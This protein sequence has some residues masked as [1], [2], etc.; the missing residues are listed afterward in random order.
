MCVGNAP[1]NTNDLY[2]E[3]R[4]YTWL[5]V[6]PPTYSLFELGGSLWNKAII[7]LSLPPGS[8]ARAHIHKCMSA[9]APSSF[10]SYASRASTYQHLESVRL[11]RLISMCLLKPSIPF[12]QRACEKARSPDASISSEKKFDLAIRLLRRRHFAICCLSL[13]TGGKDTREV[14]RR[15]EAAQ[16]TPVQCAKRLPKS[17]R[18][19]IPP[20]RPPPP[21]RSSSRCVLRVRRESFNRATHPV[22]PAK[23]FLSCQSSVAT[24]SSRVS[25]G[26]STALRGSEYPSSL[27]ATRN[28]QLNE[29]RDL[30]HTPSNL[31]PLRNDPTVSVQCYS[32]V[33]SIVRCSRRA[34][35]IFYM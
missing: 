25:A 4:M 14:F 23:R 8:R 19:H 30:T 12:W 29:K 27:L 5:F 28:T 13:C 21:C 31:K 6:A 2:I 15:V 7:P 22:T 35:V 1:V 3:R 16:K 24:C 11:L 20:T 34:P 33:R 26:V 9:R 18:S 17:V 10:L 32:S